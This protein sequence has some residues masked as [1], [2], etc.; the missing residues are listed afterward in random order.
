MLNLGFSVLFRKSAIVATI[1]AW[2]T[3]VPALEAVAGTKVFDIPYSKQM[4]AF[5]C[6]HE[7]F[8][9]V[10]AYW[11]KRLSLQEVMGSLGSH[12]T[13][14]TQFEDYVKRRFGDFNF[15]W[16]NVDY[17]AVKRQLDA[18]RPIMIGVDASVL[19]YLDYETMSGHFVT[20][21]GYNDAGQI[22]YLRD[23]NTP[24]IE[25]VPFADLKEAV[26]NTDRAAFVVYRKNGGPVA[27]NQINHFS[28]AKAFGAKKEEKKGIPV[29]WLIPRIHASYEN[30]PRTTLAEGFDDTTGREAWRYHLNWNG[31]TWGHSTLEQTPWLGN[32]KIFK[33]TGFGT[34]WI[35]GRGLR[36]GATELV[37]PGVYTF[38][39]QRGLDVRNFS[40]T[41]KIPG[42]IYNKWTL[43]A[44]GYQKKDNDESV[45]Y[46]HTGMEV[47]SFGGGRIALRRGIS[48]RIGHFS[49]GVHPAKVKIRDLRYTGEEK[50]AEEVVSANSFDVTLGIVKGSFQSMSRAKE[51]ASATSAGKDALSVEAHSFGVDYN[52][53][54]L[55]SGALA[56]RVIN[57]SGLLRPH[58]EYTRETIRRETLS[59]EVLTQSDKHW[60]LELPVMTNIGTLNYGY[61][62]RQIEIGGDSDVTRSGWLRL[63]YDGLMPFAQL[64]IGYRVD[65]RD[66][67]R[68]DGQTLSMGLSAGI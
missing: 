37:S 30:L 67:D 45:L 44:G 23:P 65:W 47:E 50:D 28:K 58:F 41:K 1:T 4:N 40:T 29:S 63:S 56:I 59:G 2:A 15:E 12:G 19:S 49:V 17:G 42:L 36:T 53:G 51:E 21:V 8:R 31:V 35:I 22:V 48:Q 20:L 5:T 33:M 9:M 25:S 39:R 43:E 6:G 52:L 26:D 55:A 14:V 68:A 13:T 62:L 7:N 24:Y 46:G 27:Q 54:Q 34:S 66:T 10:M 38:G 11:D 32:G 3:I 57:Y 61:S 64:Q 18:G 60:D 16:V